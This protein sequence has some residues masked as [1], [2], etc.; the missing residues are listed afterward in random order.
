MS[1]LGEGGW[2][3]GGGEG[4][5]EGGEGNATKNGSDTSSFAK[6]PHN[7]IEGGGVDMKRLEKE[8]VERAVGIFGVCFEGGEGGERG[9]C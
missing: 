8:V 1:G 5:G 2:N 6:V 4:R 3:K 9:E 7:V